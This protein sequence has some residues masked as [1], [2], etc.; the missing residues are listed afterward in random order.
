MGRPPHPV[1]DRL[2]QITSFQ[3]ALYNQVSIHSCNNLIRCRHSFAITFSKIN[4]FNYLI[5]GMRLAQSSYKFGFLLGVLTL[6]NS[7]EKA[8]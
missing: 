1:N 7:R 5:S 8:R 4:V 6:Y 3:A 2:A